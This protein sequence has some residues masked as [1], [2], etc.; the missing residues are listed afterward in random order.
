MVVATEEVENNSG[1]NIG[2]L[3]Q[4]KKFANLEHDFEGTVEKIYDHALLVVIT[5]NDPEDQSTVNE[6]NHRAII[7]M[8]ETEVLI[9]APEPEP[10]ATDE[11]ADVV[12]DGE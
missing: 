7:R 1:F 9:P 2:D 10:V 6:Y 12:A 11:A 8:S 4:A 5:E 3:V